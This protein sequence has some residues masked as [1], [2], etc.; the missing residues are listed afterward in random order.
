VGKQ[1]ISSIALSVDSQLFDD[2]ENYLDFC[3]EYGYKFNEADLN[4]M[5]SYSFQQYSKFSSGKPAK[6]M[7]EVDA[8]RFGCNI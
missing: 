6:N 4:N 5:R 1:K 8:E 2:L 3:R 7:W